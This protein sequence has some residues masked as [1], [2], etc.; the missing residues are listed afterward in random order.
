MKYSSAVIFGDFLQRCTLHLSMRPRT[1]SGKLINMQDQ[2][3]A[4]DLYKMVDEHEKVCR[5]LMNE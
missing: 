4:R 1:A 5:R 3:E 2:L